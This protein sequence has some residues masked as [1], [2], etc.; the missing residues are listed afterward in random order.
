M[1]MT[2]STRTLLVLSAALSGV[3]AV[4]QAQKTHEIQ[5]EANREKDVYRFSPARVTAAPGDILVFKV[6][7]G[8]PHSIVFE[9]K[10]LPAAARTALSQALGSRQ[11]ELTSPMLA[12][13][14]A[15]YRLVV[16]KLPEGNY[17]YFC[18]PH[19]AYDMRG[20]IIVKN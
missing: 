4:A 12:K 16:P 14:G 15:V 6:V 5:L 8:A 10:E 17:P 20:E 1:P 11:G 13:N 7:S 18:L 9:G 19:R 2:R 3:T